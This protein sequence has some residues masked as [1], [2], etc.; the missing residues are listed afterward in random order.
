MT[1][2]ACADCGK[3]MRALQARCRC[4]W[5]D[6][7]LVPPDKQRTAGRGHANYC[8]APTDDGPCHNTASMKLV[9]GKW[10]CREHYRTG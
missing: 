9:G 8:L 2:K 7:T 6:P 1:T 10:R 5:I 3:P 4:G